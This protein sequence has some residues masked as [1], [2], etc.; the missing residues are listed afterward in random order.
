MFHCNI[1]SRETKTKRKEK[2]PVYFLIL[3]ILYT[4]HHREVSNICIAIFRGEFQLVTVC[5]MLPTFKHVSLRTALF[6]PGL[7]SHLE[8]LSRLLARSEQDEVRMN[9]DIHTLVRESSISRQDIRDILI[10]FDSGLIYWHVTESFETIR[11]QVENMKDETNVPFTLSFSFCLMLSRW[12]C[13]PG[14][15]VSFSKMC[16]SLPNNATTLQ[17]R[18]FERRIFTLQHGTCNSKFVFPTNLDLFWEND[19]I[20]KCYTMKD[21]I[22]NWE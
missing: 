1:D 22:Q 9:V 20:F 8:Y 11:E 16:I 4:S 14:I 12:E 18:S 13:K 17:E 10:S 15:T 7:H 6:M 5:K 21:F 3:P 19:Q 2:P